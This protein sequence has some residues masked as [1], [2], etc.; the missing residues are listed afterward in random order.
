LRAIFL[1]Y[2]ERIEVIERIEIIEA[3]QHRIFFDSLDLN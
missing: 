3:T 1:E 2:I